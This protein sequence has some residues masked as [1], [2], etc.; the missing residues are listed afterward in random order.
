MS[1]VFVEG[2]KSLPDLLKL[3]ASGKGLSKRQ[4]D[5]LADLVPQQLKSSPCFL[6]RR[7]GLWRY[8]FGSPLDGL[9]SCRVVFGTH[10]YH[11]LDRLIDVLLCAK[12]RLSKEQLA[13]YLKRI[14]DPNKHADLIFEFA[15]VV[16]L[17]DDV[18]TAYEVVGYGEGAS[19]IDWLISSQESPSLLLEVKHRTR[20][21][22]ESL[23]K[24][25]EDQRDSNGR[26]LAPVH[27]ISLLFRNIEKKFLPRSSNEMLQGAW[28][29]T[30]IKQE[31]EELRMAFA[32]LDPQRI[33]FTVLGD[34]KD[35][36]YVLCDDE[37]VRNYVLKV[38]QCSESNRFVFSRSEG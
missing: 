4:V 17:P 32:A 12:R 27:D 30:D 31:K 23:I 14:D 34:F 6:D 16:R 18:Q 29:C 9:S 8:S 7:T 24:I 25:D 28:I 22:L 5:G 19:N 15:P 20:D 21:L 36:V 35:D 33:H 13:D 3:M 10:M 37:K 2:V 11:P 1:N 38:F 26:A